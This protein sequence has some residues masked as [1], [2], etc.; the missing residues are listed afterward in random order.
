MSLLKYITEI[1]E[2]NLFASA[3]AYRLF[4]DD[5]SPRDSTLYCGYSLIR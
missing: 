2:V 5:F 4:Y 1:L 3:Y